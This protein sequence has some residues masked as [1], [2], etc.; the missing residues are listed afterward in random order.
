MAISTNST[1]ISTG[2]ATNADE[3]TAIQNAM[4]NA[5]DNAD[6][7]FGDEW[8]ATGV[9]EVNRSFNRSTGLWEARVD[10]E[11]EYTG[12]DVIDPSA[13]QAVPPAQ[14]ISDVNFDAQ[15]ETTPF[16][17]TPVA[18]MTQV[19]T[20]ADVGLDA[21]GGQGSDVTVLPVEQ[22][23]G[24]IPQEVTPNE[25][26]PNETDT[27]EQQAAQDQVLLNQARQQAVLREQK[28]Q[29]ANGDWRV[30]LRLAPGANYLYRDEQPGILQPLAV[31]DGV[32]FPY[33]PQI[34]TIY[35]ANYNSYDL[36]HSNF[37]GQ[38]YQNS[39]TDQVNITATFTAQDTME[40]NYMLAVIHFFRSVTKM[41]YG[42]DAQRGA[43]PPLVFLQGLGE[44]QYNLHPCVVSQFQYNLPNDVDYIRA[45]TANSTANT[46][47]QRRDLVSTPSNIFESVI[48]RLNGSGL[49]PG[50]GAVSTSRPPPRTL[51]TSNP[52]YVPTKIEMVLTLLPIQTREQVSQ[53]FSLKR[54]ANG[55]LIRG[56]FW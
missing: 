23:T 39:F 18:D 55:D 1:Q 25:P 16:T 24:V 31:T 3:A 4:N 10:M 21:F 42:Q 40:A 13:V 19:V 8:F 53:Q 46:V 14:D 47:A 51:G 11:I 5:I 56:G 9:D 15:S 30:K 17:V 2:V 33:T 50:G 27:G 35:A 54:F 49:L 29:A 38:F 20:E 52:T 22:R 44:Y 12:P 45:R 37:R 48:N 26:S 7:R 32:V 6:A 36:T 43:P 28:N 34:N 41:F